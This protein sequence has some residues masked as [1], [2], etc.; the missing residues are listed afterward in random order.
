[1]KIFSLS[2]H[3]HACSARPLH[4]VQPP[5]NLSQEQLQSPDRYMVDVPGKQVPEGVSLY[6]DLTSAGKVLQS[7]VDAMGKLSQHAQGLRRPVTTF[8]HA[9]ASN[10]M[11]VLAVEQRKLVGM[12]KAGQKKLF[13]RNTAGS[14]HE[15]SPICLLDFYV[16]EG[17]QRRGIGTQLIQQLL[18]H[19]GLA[20][21]DLALDRPS[22]R[23]LR[24]MHKQF[25]LSQP[26]EQ[27]N[28]FSVYPGFF[29]S[30]SQQR[31]NAALAASS[32][33]PSTGASR[34]RI[35]TRRDTD[36]ATD[37]WHSRTM[38]AY[39]AGQEETEYDQAPEREDTLVPTRAR[40][41][42]NHFHSS[43][44]AACLRQDV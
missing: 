6:T 20:A 18:Q 31:R 16:E 5:D 33:S 27:E 8:T 1:M 23:L 15:T 43:G 35:S 2:N 9:K 14:L 7:V 11:L 30:E 41:R 29:S 12:L 24:F 13:L 40:G 26:L 38:D 10:H 39:S 22:P 28:Q 4:A 37:S 34:A 42:H 19:T 3:Y 32:S 21:E 17:S 36:N 25:G 44:V